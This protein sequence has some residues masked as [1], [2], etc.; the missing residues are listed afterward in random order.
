LKNISGDPNFAPIK[1]SV[2]RK[3]NEIYVMAGK[4]IA[5]F[6]NEGSELFWFN[7]KNEFH[8]LQISSNGDIYTA[9]NSGISV[10]NYR[11]VFKKKLDLSSIPNFETIQIGAMH[12]GQDNRIYVGEN[13]GRIIILDL[14]GKFLH[15]FG[16]K[17]RAEGELLNFTKIATGKDRIYVLDPQLFKIS[18]FDKSGKFLFRFGILSGLA[19]GFS[20]PVGMEVHEEMIYVMDINRMVAIAFDKDGKF[21]F[22]FGGEANGQQF[23][24]PRDIN[25][26]NDGKIY[27][28]DGGNKMV[29]VYK[30]VPVEKN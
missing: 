7:I 29:Q 12:I 11:G 18:V 13:K 4:T 6:D 16:K 8:S 22:E 2:D 25:V 9:S 24:W 5:I 21:Q 30:V 14:N 20:M 1:I 15:Q 23:L 26:D 28:A 27:V 10:F 19:G 17:G 3:H